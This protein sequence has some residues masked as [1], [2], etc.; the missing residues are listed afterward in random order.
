LVHFI[1]QNNFYIY[2]FLSNL[3]FIF[4]RFGHLFV[5]IVVGNYSTVRS[6]LRSIAEISGA[7]NGRTVQCNEISKEM[8]RA[9]EIVCVQA[10]RDL[11]PLSHPLYKTD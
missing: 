10:P 9:F 11:N 1:L 4:V 2:S 5:N 3:N 8:T 6:K 7:L